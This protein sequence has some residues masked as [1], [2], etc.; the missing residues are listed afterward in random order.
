MQP[1]WFADSFESQAGEQSVD[2]SHFFSFTACHELHRLKRLLAT[3]RPFRPISPCERQSFAENSP[4]WKNSRN[5]F[6]IRSATQRF[7]AWQPLRMVIRP[8]ASSSQPMFR[9]S[10]GIT[11]KLL[12]QS[13]AAKRCHGNCHAR[14]QPTSWDKQTRSPEHY[15]DYWRHAYW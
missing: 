13:S 14:R 2:S 15:P 1:G 10:P 5:C 9:R 12:R 7:Q 4:G 8:F 11:A 6:W 3:Y